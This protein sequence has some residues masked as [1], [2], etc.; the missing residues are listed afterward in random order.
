[1]HI[2]N[3][4]AGDA[5]MFVSVDDYMKPFFS[6]RPFY[7]PKFTV[8]MSRRLGYAGRRLRFFGELYLSQGLPDEMFL[9][10]CCNDFPVEI[11]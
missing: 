3:F 9:C 8:E 2:G 10:G 5:V 6:H 7:K 4:C 11:G 1:M